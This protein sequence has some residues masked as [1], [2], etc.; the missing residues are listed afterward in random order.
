MHQYGLWPDDMCRCC[1]S[2]SEDDTI[3]ILTCECELLSG[4]RDAIMEEFS[5]NCAR[6][7]GEEKVITMLL[8][9]LFNDPEPPPSDL[10]SLHVLLPQLSLRNLWHVFF[11]TELTHKLCSDLL[12][13]TQTIAKII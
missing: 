12:C 8:G 5:S 1:N 3:H 10:I 11:P 4:H 13:A 2:V 9:F 6:L 7:E